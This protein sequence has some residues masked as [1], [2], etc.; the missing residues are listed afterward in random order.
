MLP[1]GEAWTGSLIHRRPDTLYDVGNGLQQLWLDPGMTSSSVL[2]S[3]GDDLPRAH[4]PG[5]S[6]A[7]AIKDL[8]SWRRNPLQ[9]RATSGRG[10]VLALIRHR[11]SH[12]P[13]ETAEHAVRHFPTHRQI[14]RSR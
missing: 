11:Y 6:P 3:E 4:P 5:D 2:L 1:F 9:G 7:S 8:M 12:Q 10:V 14:A 13:T